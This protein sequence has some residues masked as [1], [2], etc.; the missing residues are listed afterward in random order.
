M[1]KTS[2]IH[3][4]TLTPIMQVE[5]CDFAFRNGGIFITIDEQ[6]KLCIAADKLTESFNLISYFDNKYEILFLDSQSHSELKGKYLELA[7]DTKFDNVLDDSA[8]I[9]DKNALDGFLQIDDDI[10]ASENSA[11]VIQFVNGLFFQAIRQRA[12]DIHIEAFEYDGYIRFRIDGVLQHYTKVKKNVIIS[13]INRIKVI[14]NL[15]ISETRI[16][17]DG[18]TKIKIAD[19][20]LDIRISVLPTYHG[21]R[22]VMRL[23]MKSESIPKLTSLGFSQ[24]VNDKLQKLLKKSYGMILITGPTGSGKSTTLHSYLQNI[25]HNEKN[26]I[27]VEDP[28]EYN[29]TG[30]NQVQ[31]NDKVGLTFASTLRSILRQ[32]PDVILVGE[33]RDNETAKIS[34]QAAMTGHLLLSTL[35]TNNAA[36][37]IARL[38]DMQIDSFLVASTLIGVM[39]QRLVRVLCSHC[40][41]EEFMSDAD[42]QYFDLDHSTHIYKATGCSKCNN[43]GYVGRIAVG[44]IILIDDNF[45]ELLKKNPDE[46]SIKEYLK[47]T[48]AFIPMF[49]Q[50]KE[51]VLAG[52]TSPD[53]AV[54]IGVKDI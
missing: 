50:I 23:L 20:N 29:A 51:L 7:N 45:L 3:D 39:A 27:T 22:V 9:T 35:H 2:V 44:E 14:S 43:T 26:I 6:T 17:Q 36:G 40:K 24:N 10:L 4:L 31:V 12:T 19:K 42:C 53:E 38:M 32:D 8:T 47:S 18:R 11:P 52:T 49:D 25:D 54:R 37:A 30:I 21:E 33:I 15:D 41:K 46:H 34:I 1:L 16:P 5:D 48:D 28:V 13:I